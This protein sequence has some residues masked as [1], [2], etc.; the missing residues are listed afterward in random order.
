MNCLTVLLVVVA[1]CFGLYIGTPL[2]EDIRNDPIYANVFIP[3]GH[4]GSFILSN[5]DY[6]AW[7]EAGWDF[8][9]EP[10]PSQKEGWVCMPSTSGT[11]HKVSKNTYIGC[12]FEGSNNAGCSN[13][14]VN[15][16]YGNYVGEIVD[17]PWWAI[18]QV[19]GNT[20]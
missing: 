14:L 13:L 16:K 12:C 9:D 11:W 5:P 4:W 3:R 17:S 10:M 18:Q 19:I 6:N 8:S 15:N 1:I 7:Q 20:P 2:G